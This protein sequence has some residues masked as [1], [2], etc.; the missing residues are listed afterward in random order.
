VAI[1]FALF[2][3]VPCLIQGDWPPTGRV[4]GARAAHQ[5]DAIRHDAVGVI[6][7]SPQLRASTI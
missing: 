4:I 3:T 5:R 6:Q 2:F 1:R 7:R